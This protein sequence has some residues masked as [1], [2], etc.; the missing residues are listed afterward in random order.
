MKLYFFCTL[1]ILAATAQGQ[2][3]TT[4]AAERSKSLKSALSQLSAKAPPEQLRHVH[5]Q[6]AKWQ[7]TKTEKD[8]VEV[9]ERVYMVAKASDAKSDVTVATSSGKGA[10]VK[11]QTLG[12]RKRNEPPTT[13]KGLTVAVESMYI[14]MYHIWSERGASPTSNKDD[15][16]NIAAPT[17]TVTLQENK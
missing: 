9:S 8:W 16:F 6:A 14:G 11:Y 5:A 10:S 2:E 13:A 4:S 17:E 3:F 15:Q 7:Q 1:A 12:Q